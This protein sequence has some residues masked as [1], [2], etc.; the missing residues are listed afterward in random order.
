MSFDDAPEVAINQIGLIENAG[1]QNRMYE[2]TLE[3]W[4]EKDKLAAQT[5]I[6]SANLPENVL[7]SISKSNTP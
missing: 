7:K 6:N 2:R 5:W 3:A 1:S 4:L